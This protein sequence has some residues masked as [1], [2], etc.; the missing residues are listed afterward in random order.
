M[1]TDC[2]KILADLGYK[3][4]P[5]SAK[6]LISEVIEHC[7]VKL[8]GHVTIDNL[9]SSIASEKGISKHELL[10]NYSLLEK[11]IEDFVGPDSMLITRKTIKEALRKAAN[12]FDEEISFE[13]MIESIQKVEVLDFLSN[14]KGSTTPILFYTQEKFRT[15]IIDG[16]L[17]PYESSKISTGH[18]SRGPTTIKATQNITYNELVDGNQ[19]VLE[20]VNDFFSKTHAMNSSNLPTR[21]SCEDT[22]WFKEEGFSDEHQSIRHS[23]NPEII[24]NA[25]ILCSYDLNKISEEEFKKLLISSDYVLLDNPFSVY[26]KT[27]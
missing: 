1:D 21:F 2:Q 3:K 25:I 22:I 12:I 5:G 13:K 9:I 23:L 27:D 19:M 18:F 8:W 7:L 24:R 10:S 14:M 26:E 15:E 16:Y 11:G 20:R 17:N 4:I 6:S